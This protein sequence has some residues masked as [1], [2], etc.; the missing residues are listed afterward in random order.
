MVI[1]KERFVSG[2]DFA[3]YLTTVVTKREDW[4]KNY[5]EFQLSESEKERLSAINKPFNV[6]A[7]SEDWCPDSFHNLPVIAKMVES[8]PRANLKVFPRDQNLDLMDQFTVN[9][10]RKI[11]TVAFIDEN[12]QVL[13]VWI[14]EPAKA[15]ELKEKFA[16]QEVGEE[17]YLS[18]LKLA[19]KQEIFAL[20]DEIKD[21]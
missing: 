12:F 8:L 1:P 18:S 10:K 4:H 7:L 14:E 15:G 19:V 5:Q 6:L 3:I 9:G 13:A 11:P 2:Y 21:R 16:N 20:L 17:K